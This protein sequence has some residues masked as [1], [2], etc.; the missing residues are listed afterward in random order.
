[1][2]KASG[3][4]GEFWGEVRGG[5]PSITEYPGQM[6][7]SGRACKREQGHIRSR[8]FQPCLCGARQL[9]A[10]LVLVACAKEHNACP[11]SYRAGP[12]NLPSVLQPVL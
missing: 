12:S 10:A 8:D 1:M 6:L 3:Y 7:R 9:T 11:T 2:G 4:L 5:R